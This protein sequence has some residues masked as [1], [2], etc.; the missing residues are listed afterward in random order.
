MTDRLKIIPNSRLGTPFSDGMD[1]D[2]NMRLHM[3]ENRIVI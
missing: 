2:I 1:V 3:L